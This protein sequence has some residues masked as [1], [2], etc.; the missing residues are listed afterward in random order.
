M[1]YGCQLPCR[2]LMHLLREWCFL[3]R[4]KEGKPAKSTHKWLL[5]SVELQALS[6][7]SKTHPWPGLQLPYGV[8]LTDNAFALW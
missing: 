6:H 1:S 8:Q 5:Y 2:L 4:L 7:T 3:Q